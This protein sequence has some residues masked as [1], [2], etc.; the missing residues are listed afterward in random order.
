MKNKIDWTTIRRNVYM[1]LGQPC[2]C[3]SWWAIKC[4]LYLIS[5]VGKSTIALW[6]R[7]H[8]VL[9]QTV[10]LLSFG[11]WNWYNIVAQK[12]QEFT[13]LHMSGP[14]Y[15]LN[16]RCPNLLLQITMVCSRNPIPLFVPLRMISLY[17]CLPVQHSFWIRFYSFNFSSCWSH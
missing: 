12:I 5:Q 8:D 4:N 10:T 14:L 7:C 16:L 1:N 11:P 15:R 17:V 2:G 9:T 3:D 13:N 6:G